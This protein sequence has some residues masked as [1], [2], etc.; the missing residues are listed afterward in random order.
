[1]LSATKPTIYGT[2]VLE[3]TEVWA[4]RNGADCLH[5]SKATIRPLAGTHGPLDLLIG[6]KSHGGGLE[7]AARIPAKIG[8]VAREA[9]SASRAFALA[10]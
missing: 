6:P 9:V 4:P 5:R 8:N 1:M 7:G 3:K 10:D 2:K